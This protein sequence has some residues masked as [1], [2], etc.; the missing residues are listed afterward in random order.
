MTSA[1]AALITVVGAMLLIWASP[2]L[3][4]AQLDTQIS[5]DTIEVGGT[6]RVKLTAMADD[7]PDSP[8]LAVPGSFNVSGP[9]VGTNHKVSIVNGRMSRQ[10]G[11]TATWHVSAR[12]E[13]EFVIGP[14]SV[15]TSG[16]RVSGQQFRIKVVPRGSLPP[17][18][19][20]R[21]RSPFGLFDDDDDPFQGR[22]GRSLFDDMFGQ[23]R[24]QP[25]PEAPAEYQTERALDNIAFLRAEAIPSSVVVGEQVTLRIYAY[26]ARGPFDESNSKE[27]RRP[28][29]FSHP[30]VDRMGKQPFYVTTIDDEQFHVV[31]LR[32]LALFPLSSGRKEIGPMSMK[33]AGRRYASAQVPEG[34]ER[35]TQPLFIDVKE[36]PVQGRPPN[37]VAGDVGQFE[38]RAQVEPRTVEA[39]GSVSV[40]ATVSGI[41]N[42]PSRVIT[43]EQHGLQWLQPTINDELRAYAGSRIGGKR[44]FQYV[45]RLDKPGKVELGQ[46]SLPF[47]DPKSGRYRT[48]SADLGAIVV[49]PGE[50]ARVAS[51]S[52]EDTKLSAAFAPRKA[53]DFEP[54]NRQLSDSGWFWGLLGLAPASV[55]GLQLSNRLARRFLRRRRAKLGSSWQLAKQALASAEI[56]KKSGDQAA[57]LGDVERATFAAIEAATGLK[58]RAILRDDLGRQLLEA[59]IDSETAAEATSLLQECDTLRYAGQNTESL[60]AEL[61]QRTRRLVKSIRATEKS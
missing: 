46:L 17:P 1:Q 37:Y 4:Q 25:R 14:A 55:F 24:L 7:S 26:G 33:F 56:S 22:P 30:L 45:V 58:A 15:N 59:G 54:D 38:L 43:P 10:A 12:K 35:R 2:V 34:V 9:S 11:I 40:V 50:Q 51:Q 36:P 52:P 48:A 28:D 31:K 61:L 3:A 53:G 42:F 47:Y 60:G 57:L 32:E 39:G 44:T 49:T 20:P 41:G 29:F 5:S 13:G 27:P 21:R 19:Q 23:P 16:G 18:K 6:L 8:R